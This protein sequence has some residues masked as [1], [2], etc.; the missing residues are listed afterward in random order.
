MMQSTNWNIST[1]ITLYF[2]PHKHDKSD[3]FYRNVN[4]FIKNVSYIN[5]SYMLTKS[6]QEKTTFCTSYKKDKILW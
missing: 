1:Q 2:R 4:K 3:S 5:Q 6:F